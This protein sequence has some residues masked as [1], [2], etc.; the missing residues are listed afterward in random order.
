[1]QLYKGGFALSSFIFLKFSDTGTDMLQYV[2]EKAEPKPPKTY[3]YQGKR[4]IHIRVGFISA[5]K[6]YKGLDHPDWYAKL[7]KIFDFKQLL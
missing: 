5:G 1:M 3:G 7:L 6:F 2:M 4:Q